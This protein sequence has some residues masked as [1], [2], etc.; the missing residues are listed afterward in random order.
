MAKVALSRES[1]V[2]QGF[3]AGIWRSLEIGGTPDLGAGT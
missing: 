2:A 3:E 1:G